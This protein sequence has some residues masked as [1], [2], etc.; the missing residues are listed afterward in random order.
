MGTNAFHDQLRA[1]T[2]GVSRA[3]PAD[4]STLIAIHLDSNKLFD[5][6]ALFPRAELDTHVPAPLL[7]DAIEDG[8]VFVV[9]RELNAPIGFA[10]GRMFGDSLYLDQVSVMRRHGQQGYGQRLVERFVDEGRARRL[11]SVTLS[12]FRTVPWNAPFYR[13]LGFR[14]LP[15]RQKTDWMREIEA[16]QAASM[17]LST[18]CFMIRRLK[19]LFHRA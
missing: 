15:E 18:R 5:G 9:R 13:K 17:D 6:L 7:A 12:T 4:I 10:M 16:A 2:T 11:A 19:G 3:T 1:E 14:E 8:L